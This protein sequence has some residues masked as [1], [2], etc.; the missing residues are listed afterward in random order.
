MNSV[1]PMLKFTA[2]TVHDF[3][4][5]RLAT[6]D[7]EVEVTKME[8][9]DEMVE[10]ISFSYYQKPMKTPLVIGASTAMSLHQKFSILSNEVIRRLSNMSPDR[11]SSE[12]TEVINQ[13]T[14]ELK[15]CGYTSPG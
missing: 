7:M 2:E 13:F 12:K 11:T 9:K 14:R 5:R 15:N 3:E 6:L 4:N 1:S 10:Q 8:H